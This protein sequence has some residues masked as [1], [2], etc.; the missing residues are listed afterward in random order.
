MDETAAVFSIVYAV[1]Y[2]A[3]LVLVLVAQWIIFTKA[4]E[5]GWKIFIPFYNMYIQFKI[6]WGNGWFF[7]LTFVPLVN[8]IILIICY[9]KLAQS[10]GK[11]A[12][13]AVGLIFLPIIFFPMLAF[14]SA[15]YIGPQ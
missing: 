4:G 15:Q 3:I 1:V 8:V 6:A 13:F 7:L 14:G 10:F 9:V 5:K 12:G 11:G 2:L